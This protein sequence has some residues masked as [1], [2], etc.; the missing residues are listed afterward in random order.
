ML[1]ADSLSGA[2]LETFAHRSDTT[3][4]D[5]TDAAND[6]AGR[7]THRWSVFRSLITSTVTVFPGVLVDSEGESQLA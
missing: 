4:G 7:Q 5:V 1:H 6:Q 3:T 2:L